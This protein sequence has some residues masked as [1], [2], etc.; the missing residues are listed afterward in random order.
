MGY[1]T[2]KTS[3]YD[4]SA[5]PTA[6][7]ANIQPVPLLG[8]VKDNIDPNRTG[9]IRVYLLDNSG[10]DENDDGAWKTLQYLSPFFGRTSPQGP[11]S[12]FGEYKLNSSSY[13]MWFSPPDI[14]TTVVCIFINGDMSPQ[15]SF[16][17]G[18]VPDPNALRMVPAI[19]ANFDTEDVVFNEG[20]ATSLSGV[21]RVPV[22]NMNSNDPKLSNTNSF[23]TSAKTVHSYSS[24]ILFQQGIIRDPIRGPISSSAQRESPSRVGWGVSTPGRPIYEGG[25][26][27]ETLPE[28][29]KNSDKNGLKI[30]SRRGGHSFV[31]DDGD[32]SGRDQLVRIRSSKG[33]QIL[34]SDDGQ[35]LMLL[36]SNGQSYVELGK[37]GTVDI[38]ST[39]SVN[40]RTQGDLNLH[41]DNNVNIHANKE[42]KIHAQNIQ[43]ESE[44]DYNLKVG[45]NCQATV[46]GK[47]TV[48]SAGPLALEA[49]S[50]ASIVSA[51]ITYVK[52]SLVLLNTGS[53]S[54]K[55]AEVPPMTIIAHTD[56][57]FDDEK[58]YLAAPGKLLSITSRAPAHAPWAHANQGVDVNVDLAASSQLP[59]PPTGSLLESNNQLLDP[60]IKVDS[61]I[62]S[63]MPKSAGAISQTLTQSVTAAML[64][65]SATAA[66]LD[67]QSAVKNGVSVIKDA[68][69]KSKVVVGQFAQTPEQLESG[70]V[71]KPGSAKL[72][73][74]LI[75]GGANPAEALTNN[76]FTG[77]SG[78][79][80][81]NELT[82]SVGAQA[83]SLVSNFQQ[84]QTSLTST[85][86]I[87]GRED[88]AQI[89]GSVMSVA[90]EGLAP[91]LNSIAA[92]SGGGV[93]GQLRLGSN[94]LTSLTARFSSGSFSASVGLGSLTAGVSKW[95]S[96]GNFAA[97]L[98]LLKSGF[99]SFNLS[100][101]GMKRS[102]GVSQ[103]SLSTS[104]AVA[105][106]FKAISASLTPFK[107]RV[108]QN[109]KQLA[110]ESAQQVEE[111]SLN[112]VGGNDLLSAVNIS[113]SISTDSGRA[114]IN[115]N[116]EDILTAGTEGGT[117]NLGRIAISGGSSGR[118]SSRFGVSLNN[119]G[120]SVSTGLRGTAGAAG[121]NVRLPQGND[122][123]PGVNN[124]SSTVN[125]LL[126]G[127]LDSSNRTI[128]L[129]G[130]PAASL[131]S[132]VDRLP[133]GQGAIAQLVN[134]NGI[135]VKVPGLD[136]IKAL[137]NGAQTAAMNGLP[138]NIDSILGQNTGGLS[139]LASTGLPAGPAAQL[140]AAISSVGGGSSVKLPTIGVETNNRKAV[141]SSI[142][143]ILGDPG[144]P[145]PSFTGIP[146]SGFDP[147][148]ALASVPPSVPTSGGSTTT[149]ATSNPIVSGSP[150]SLFDQYEA[151]VKQL[152]DT[153]L[154]HIRYG[155]NVLNPA[156][157]SRDFL[158]K[159]LPPGDPKIAEAVKRSDAAQAEYE[160]IKEKKLVILDE[161]NALYKAMPKSKRNA[162]SQSPSALFWSYGS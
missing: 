37:E 100:I 4:R 75:E 150:D 118:N 59:I 131:A 112:G 88:P 97:G 14:G 28:A 49:L 44:T 115:G 66:A 7:G 133:G 63:A 129:A 162:V 65:T 29:L 159:T 108:P 31:M 121:I 161:L 35:T 120:I 1:N 3:G 116:L 87:T 22:T 103:I 11:D 43:V 57:L 73:N 135:A 17:I 156:G 134:N 52:G 67:A 113:T 34:M 39:N 6:G 147:T 2:T 79:A 64:G 154:E 19:G 99:G 101:N 149:P 72:V 158:E 157:Q 8:I 139:A 15:T 127:I 56:T 26:W 20:E 128:S 85:G 145:A 70:G 13:G 46:F 155:Q 60:A 77:K 32:A 12:G 141:S 89:A 125:M 137:I 42:F 24:S 50:E 126:G 90:N 83:T 105:G 16:Y 51:S 91:T 18:A 111:N 123:Y 98:S 151:K 74:S 54:T 138:D 81:L 40:I 92:F 132:G 114:V 93:T 144:I 140:Q 41:A 122:S 10:A 61:G 38:Y 117:P 153:D 95:M 109:L 96:S 69:G 76:L 86:L 30:I 58:G 142:D 71:L 119:D 152:L 9:R 5:N 124:P 23:I 84:A 82:N 21:I 106:A 45:A 27:D 102:L 48:K 110:Q 62:I 53:P 36:H 25:Y 143:T 104:G 107:P 80:N 68:T 130:N 146:P 47:Y 94:S 160:K 33:H 78:A 148:A 136:K 55:P